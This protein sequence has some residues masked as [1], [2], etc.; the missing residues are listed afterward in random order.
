MVETAGTQ[1][2]RCVQHQTAGQ[3]LKLGAPQTR[4]VR[5]NPLRAFLLQL[6]VVLSGRRA[7]LP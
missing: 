2:A 5:T 6:A 4:D 3:I 7:H 1:Q